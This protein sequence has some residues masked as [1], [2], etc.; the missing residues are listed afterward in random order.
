MKETILP[1]DRIVV[2]KLIYGPVLPR[3]PFE[4]PW[5]NIFYYIYSSSFEKYEYISWKYKRLNGFS[6]I[7]HQDIVVFRLSE[8]SIETFIKRCV[9]LPGDTIQIINSQVYIN[10]NKQIY[11]NSIKYK[12]RIFTSDQC[13][14]EEAL[15]KSGLLH[16]NQFYA[17]TSNECYIFAT[18][19]ELMLIQAY[20]TVDSVNRV[21]ETKEVGLQFSGDSDLEWSIDFFGPIVIPQKGLEIP[22]TRTNYLL[23]KD[24]L[25]HNEGIL[26]EYQNNTCKIDG[27]TVTEYAFRNDYFFVLG[28][29][30]YHSEDSRYFGMIP[31][32]LIIGRTKRVLFSKSNDQFQWKHLLR[33]LE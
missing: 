25:K 2:N 26:I 7:K 32:K 28:D 5:I 22:L 4:I 23:Y 3:S 31:E 8:K 21:C 11:P 29:N 18:D 20:I 6:K 10:G 17:P 14:L 19:N 9:A 33:K 24:I 12:Y 1:E 16:S 30:R 27:G 13:N 15:C